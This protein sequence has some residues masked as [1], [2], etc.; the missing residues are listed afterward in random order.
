MSGV[1]P[2]G[3]QFTIGWGDQRATI[4]EVGGAIREY[5]AGERAVLDPFP[6][7]A[8]ADGAHGNVLVPWPNRLADGS[9]E[10]EGQKQQ[11]PVTEPEKSN[12]IH[13]LM[14]WRNWR[15]GERTD[16]SIEMV[17]RI[18]P[19]KGYPFALDV[20][21]AYALADDGLTVTTR[22]T[23]I[24]DKACPYGCGQ[25]PY[26]SPGDG[27]IDACTLQFDAATRVDTDPERQLPTGR[28]PVH[29]TEYDFR[30]ARSLGDFQ[31][32]YAF[33][34]L[35]RDDD[36]LSWARLGGADGA[37]VE[38]WIDEAYPFLELFTGDSLAPERARRGLASEPMS[39]APNAFRS[40]DG[41]VRLEP[42]QTHTARWGVRLS[43]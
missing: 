6:L 3:E 30:E 17:A 15:V 26:L 43:P 1:A 8:M 2:S 39:C 10:W 9:Y 27:L 29:G 37:T 20:S 7:D 19:E 18:H 32:D 14:R 31:M 23:N 4:V 34:D 13:G 33:T 12:A 22:A 5:Y 36:G 40:G 11:S 41:V 25:H 24:G 28:I 16:A 35:G 42:G 21:V 38:L